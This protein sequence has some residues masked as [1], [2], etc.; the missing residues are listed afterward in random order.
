MK[1]RL[2]SI[3]S[4][5]V[6][7]AF[8]G[9]AQPFIWAKSAGLPGAQEGF[10]CAADHSGNIFG[11]GYFAGP[12][13]FGRD[14]IPADTAIST[15][16]VKYDSLG[17][18][19]WVSA[20][21][22]GPACPIGIATDLYNNLYLFGWYKSSFR[23]GG[24]ELSNPVA[25]ASQSYFF[26][27][28]F[29]AAGSVLWVKQVGNMIGAG[30]ALGQAQIATDAHGNVYLA[31]A[32]TRNSVI[33][34][35]SLAAAGY[36]DICIAKFDSSGS[37]LWAKGFGHSGYQEAYGIAVTVSGNIYFD[38]VFGA[39]EAFGIT[40]P[41]T[42]HFG[43][44]TIIALPGSQDIFLV[45][46]D[47]SGNGVWAKSSIGADCLASGLAADSNENV[48]MVGNKHEGAVNMS[49]YS[50][51]TPQLGFLMKFDSSGDVS[52]VKNITVGTNIYSVAIDPCGFPWICGAG[53]EGVF[54]DGHALAPTVPL[55]DPMFFAGWASDG[56]FLSATDLA[57]GGDDANAIAIDPRGNIFI[58]GDFAPDTFVIGSDSMYTTWETFFVA[59]F[60]G[61][62][63]VSLLLTAHPSDTVCPGT[64]VTFHASV[65][66]YAT[67]V[68]YQWFV[69][70]ARMG[71]TDSLYTYTP[72][73]RDS[74]RCQ[75]TAG[76]T[77][78]CI[79]QNIVNEVVYMVVT[80]P[81]PI[82][83]GG[84]LCA[85]DSTTLSD[86]PGGGA[87][88]VSSTAA[89]V[90]GSAS[91]EIT[92]IAAGTVAISYTIDSNCTV[93]KTITVNPVLAPVTSAGALCSGDSATLGDSTPGGVWSVSNTL[94]AAVGSISGT[95]TG[96]DAGMDTVSYSFGPGC[97]VFAAITVN[98]SPAGIAGSMYI[99]TGMSRTL[100]DVVTGGTW[101]LDNSAV[102]AIGSTSGIITGLS[103]GADTVTY[104]LPA[105]CKAMLVATVNP[106]PAGITGTLQLCPGDT[107]IASDTSP[108]GVWSC[109][110]PY[111][112]SINPATG[113]I[114]GLAS[115]ATDIFYTL[116]SGCVAMAMV[117]VSPL[118]A[119]HLITGGGSY[120]E[121]GAVAA[122]G[123]GG[124]EPG[125]A[126]QLYFDGSAVGSPIAG[127]GTALDF[128]LHTTIGV[129]TVIATNPVTGCTQEMPDSTVIAVTPV[130]TTYVI[131]DTAVCYYSDVELIIL[132]APVA[133]GGIWYNGSSRSVDTISGPGAYWITY[134]DTAGCAFTADTFYVAFLP[135]PS[136]ING[137]NIVCSGDTLMLGDFVTGGTWASSSPAVASV[138]EATG[139]VSAINAGQDTITYA[140]LP[141][142]SVT[143]TITIVAPPCTNSIS[144]IVN[145][146]LQIFP[147]PADDE[148]TIQL[149]DVI[150]SPA[151]GQLI[152]TNNIGQQLIHQQITSTLTTV[153]IQSLPPGM[154]YIT[155]KGAEGSVVKK[156]V[157]M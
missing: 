59:K 133:T 94:I 8:N 30:P 100:F 85:G 157:K 20:T 89:A 110:H 82:A 148:L 32:F 60:G 115:G 47:S 144:S 96:R 40:V 80:S 74:I 106:S 3:L 1:N 132:T 150:L 68:V 61:A 26:L 4:I 111:T 75:I 64:V 54:V 66:T 18:L 36:G 86:I 149:N 27:A 38:G 119:A 97:T 7:I 87:W 141:G 125:V 35:D 129:Y 46:L 130:D 12:L 123:L 44:D 81:S 76:S 117:T 124:S 56:T 128:G 69:N 34:A 88:S 79:P 17:N 121:G 104:V 63:P 101:S 5:C 140:L 127:T 65:T 107:T 108:G 131:H 135:F 105:G 72:M 90:I 24:H 49:T 83:G 98:P 116:P 155:L 113:A 92:G 21:T 37:P 29:N 151:E 112:A 73:N 23:L 114:I 15:F 22:G 139:I 28:K 6:F 13:V 99:C 42:L 93:T 91:G 153:N 154:Y 33:G 14:T 51:S 77:A 25:P 16:V 71:A 138:N 152:I 145:N 45:K 55:Y 146:T 95:V 43:A 156:F 57:G 67:P 9:H 134:S 10:E 102:A 137:N 109:V 147:N 142:C 52:W 48:Y 84:H 118:P 58:C 19:L 41:D 31:P 136:P 11:C 143:Q 62:F 120:C 53:G 126:Y 78:G 39:E 70:G 50:F 122:I 103:T 2:F